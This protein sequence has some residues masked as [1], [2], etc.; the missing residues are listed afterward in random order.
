MDGLRTSIDEFLWRSEFWSS[1]KSLKFLTCRADPNKNH[2]ATKKWESEKKRMTREILKHTGR[3]DWFLTANTPRNKHGKL[4]NHCNRKF[5]KISIFMQ[6]QFSVSS[7]FWFGI[8]L[9]SSYELSYTL[10]PPLRY[11][12]A[13]EGA[14]SSPRAFAWRTSFRIT[15]SSIGAAG[16]RE[17]LRCRSWGSSWQPHLF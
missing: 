5:H 8:Y 7:H 2:L 12:R 1:Q 14:N 9:E 6:G 16:N 11:K 4:E 3:T 15:C 13:R 17:T 10:N